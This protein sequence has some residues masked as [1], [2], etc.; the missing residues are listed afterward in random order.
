MTVARAT[1]HENIM[2][3][4]ILN[5]DALS[6]EILAAYIREWCALCE[7]WTPMTM[8]G[9]GDSFYANNKCSWVIVCTRL[10]ECHF[11][12]INGNVNFTTLTYANVE[13]TPKMA[14]IR[15][16]IAEKKKWNGRTLC[17]AAY[18][19]NKAI[20]FN[21]V[22]YFSKCICRELIHLHISTR[23]HTHIHRES[24]H[25]KH[26]SLWLST[27]CFLL[28]TVFHSAQMGVVITHFKWV[29]TNR[30]RKKEL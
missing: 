17:V 20:A 19:W 9:A 29:H 13:N 27:A 1:R 2:I 25:V 28:Q 21:F 7:H 10:I 3:Y 6:I 15:W 26:M 4:M 18:L 5:G 30:M 14:L 16:I 24:L 11:E 22:H 23:T 8:A 12:H